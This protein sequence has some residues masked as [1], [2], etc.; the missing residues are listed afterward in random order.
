MDFI[1]KYWDILL[2]AVA[3]LVVGFMTIRAFIKLPASKKWTKI[4]N[5]LLQA[6]I[7][8]EK[9]LGSKTGQAKLSYV[10]D[11]FVTKFKFISTIMP[12]STFSNLVDEVL[13]KFR[14]MINGNVELKQY[15]NGDTVHYTLA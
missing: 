4:S 6:V 11:M 3:V 7:A 2:V 1:V 8:A 14:G 13:E 10:Y 5:W 9:E 15:V 12:F